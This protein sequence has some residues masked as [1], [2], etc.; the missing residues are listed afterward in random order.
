MIISKI[1]ARE[2][3]DSRGNPT[4]EVDVGL[5]DGSSGRAAVPS[6]AS[7]GTKEA[8]ELRDKDPKRY[9]GKGVRNAV[10]N[11]NRTIAPN[12]MGMD[13][14]DQARIEGRLLQLDGT[15]NKTNLGANAILGVS[16]A[17]AKAASNSLGISLYRYIGGLNANI[18]PVPMMNILNGG[19]HADNNVDFQEFMIVPT[20]AH[21]FSQA[22]RIGVETFH[23][24]KKVLSQSGYST[25]VGDEGGFAP[26]LKS[27]IQAIELI[28]E[29]TQKAGYK[30]GE[31]VSIALD[32]AASEFLKTK[33]TYFIS[34]TAQ[35]RH[36]KKWLDSMLI[37]QTATQ[38]YQ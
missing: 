18:L 4:I 2:I 38:L 15:E 9:L 10:D 20:C 26:S 17:C 36:P 3:L 14:M 22:L 13:V 16:I 37:S 29:A 27:N 11:V 33:L 31:D 24:L 34:L 8:V 7:T 1:V 25:A 5:E 35:K 19:R 21:S 30:A 23:S 12:L 28:I 32:P 6:G